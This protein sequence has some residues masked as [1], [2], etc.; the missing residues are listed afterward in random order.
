MNSDPIVF[1]KMVDI[2]VKISTEHISDSLY[3]ISRSQVK[4]IIIT[5]PTAG[6][7]I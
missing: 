1:D 5:P 4:V 7:R 3:F 2:K 6:I